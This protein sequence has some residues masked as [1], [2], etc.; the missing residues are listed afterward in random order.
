MRR[1][2][3]VE[4]TLCN[5]KMSS[6]VFFPRTSPLEEM[7]VQTDESASRAKVEKRKTALTRSLSPVESPP[8]RHVEKTTA[9]SAHE[10]L[11]YVSVDDPGSTRKAPIRTDPERREHHQKKEF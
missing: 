9:I 1:T 3:E 10:E 4:H 6:G 11:R 7:K 5:M 8:Q 2:K